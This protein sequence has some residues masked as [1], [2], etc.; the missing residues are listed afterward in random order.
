MVIVPDSNEQAAPVR[1]Q[2]WRAYYQTHRDHL[3]AKQ[4]AR[5]KKNPTPD[6]MATTQ[7]IANNRDRRRQ[8]QQAW[9]QRNQLRLRAKHQAYYHANQAHE[10]TRCREYYATHRTAVRARQRR[11]YHRRKTAAV[12]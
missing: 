10:L 8:Q 11:Y 7:W 4:R 2:Q 5:Y 6:L 1:R 9:Y 12:N 3:A